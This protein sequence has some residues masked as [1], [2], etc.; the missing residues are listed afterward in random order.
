MRL[1]PGFAPFRV[2]LLR[3]LQGRW[4]TQTTEQA[5]SEFWINLLNVLQ[6]ADF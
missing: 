5:N 2:H 4:K 6:N 3:K 1:F